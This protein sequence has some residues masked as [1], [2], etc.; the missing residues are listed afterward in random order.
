MWE[1][2]R[3]RGGEE[4][5][6]GNCKNFCINLIVKERKGIDVESRERENKKEKKEE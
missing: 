2:R 1:G 3:G 5:E 4:K 6:K